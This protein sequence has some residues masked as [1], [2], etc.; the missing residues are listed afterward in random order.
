MAQPSSA[1]SARH[2]RGVPGLHVPRRQALMDAV[3]DWRDEKRV[4]ERLGARQ[5]AR[6]DAIVRHARNRSPYYRAHYR[7]LPDHVFHPAQL[8]IVT[9]PELMAAFDDWV[10][11][12]NVHLADVEAFLADPHLVGR[13]FRGEYAVATTSG[14]TGR[15]GVFLHDKRAL[16][17]YVGLAL[18]RG[19]PRWLT[20]RSA[21]GLVR[22]GA[23]LAAIVAT[24]SHYAALAGTEM[25]RSLGPRAA[26]RVQVFSVLDALPDTVRRL[27]A[28][29]PAVL[30]G[31]PSALALLA[32]EQTAGRL[33]LAPRVAFAGGERL[34]HVARDR[35]EAAFGCPVWDVYAATE[36]P[37]IA[38][39]CDRGWLHV[40]TDWC[41]L[42]PVDERH[43]PVPPGTPSATTLLTNLAN[44][45]QPLIRYDLGDSLVWKPSRCSCG[46]P[47]PAVR[48]QGRSDDVLAMPATTGGTVHVLPLALGSIIEETPGV[49][50]FQAI[51]HAPDALR[52]RLRA[53]D[54]ARADAVWRHVDTRVSEWL[55]RQNV[56]GVRIERD[57][58]P[59]G[60]DP[61]TGKFRQ[62]FAARA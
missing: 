23:R 54:D 28:F 31:Y 50:T 4:A 41:I 59:P 52:V 8:P 29:D 47:L 6:L 55:S 56:E 37:G 21:A 25:A 60:R 14:V 30:Y 24:G 22:D 43:E 3:R 26:K 44:R 16:A 5:E 19:L 12:A 27:Q 61:A 9:K 46:D 51:Y 38:Y 57:A 48:V 45:V 58:T 49:A 11:D 34:S 53:D 33:A 17:A 7:G 10:A 18:A 20:P 2:P 42:E 32:H 62:V 1:P 36:F 39:G 35:I 40:N 13:P 15:R